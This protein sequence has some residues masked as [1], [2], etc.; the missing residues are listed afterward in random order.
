MKR[1]KRDI[2]EIKYL[3]N[4]IQEEPRFI[5][6]LYVTKVKGFRLNS[7]QIKYVYNFL[8]PF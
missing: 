8:N 6:L 2:A 5:T 7:I 4:S 1:A 3:P